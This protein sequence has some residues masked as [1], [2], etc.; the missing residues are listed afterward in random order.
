MSS[1]EDPRAAIE[2]VDRELIAKLAERIALTR[3]VGARKGQDPGL[4]LRDEVRERELFETWVEEGERRGLSPYFLGRIL[5]EVLT[6]SRRDQERFLAVDAGGEPVRVA[7]QGAHHAYSDLA[8]R[9]LFSVR[10]SAATTVGYPSFAAALDALAA[11]DVAYALLPVE[12]TIAGSI[13]PVYRL[14]AEREV[15]VVDEEVWNVEHCLSGLPGATLTDLRHVRSHPVALAQCERFLAGLVGVQAES[16]FDTAAAADEVAAAGDPANAALCSEAAAE[17]AGLVVLARDVADASPNVTRFLLLSL[18]AESFDPRLPA[19]TSLLLT[20]DHRRGAL[21]EL[22]GVL[23]RAGCSLTKLESR[24]QPHAP[25]EYLFYVDV[26]GDAA[27]EPLLSALEEARA[28]TNQLRV[29]GSYPRR[30][31]VDAEGS[32]RELGH[33]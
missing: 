28:H 20:L 13:D 8:A 7:F 25:W 21:A 27:R 1:L 5:R 23:A 16:C 19:R 33:D 4:P 9:K 29:L 18:T 6:W 2:R 30:A 11:G 32:R 14:L 26:E 3:A 31:G 15:H 24:P 12:N 17:A 10:D 22:L